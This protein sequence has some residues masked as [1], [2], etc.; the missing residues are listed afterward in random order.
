MTEI[1]TTETKYNA[2]KAERQ[3]YVDAVLNSQSKKNIVV[4]GPGTG[5]THLFKQVLKGKT[6]TLTL[7]FVNPLV[8]DLSLELC[9]ISDVRTLHGFARSALGTATSGTVKVFPKLSDVIKEDAK[10]LL[11]KD[12]NFDHIFHNRDD[13]NEHIEFY[14]KRKNYYDKHYGYSDIIFAIVKHFESKKDKIPSYE[15]VVVDEFQ[16]F[17]KLEVSLIDLLAE[18]SPILLAGDDDQALYDFKSASPEHIRKRHAVENTDYASFTLPY[19]SRCT[20]VIVEATNDII[21]EATKNGNLNGRINKDYKYFDDEIKDK[22]CDKHP[23]IGYGQ[24][25]AKQIPWFIEQRI[26]EIAEHEK[27][28][29]SVLII[30]PTKVQIRSIVTALK[31]KGFANIQFVEKKD[32]K[33][34]NL[35]DGLKV[36]LD[37]SKSNLGW[38][39]VSK[40]LLSEADFKA[41]IT[42]TATD[43]TKNVSDLINKAHKKDV[44]RMLKILRAIKD[45]KKVDEAKLDA[46]LKKVD[47]EPY[48]MA[49]E[50]LKSEISGSQKGGN[51][52][53]R[54][55]PIK[56]TTIQSS[57]GL[58]AEYVFITNFDDQ[59]FIKNKDKKKITDQ[60][61][62]NLLVAL[63]RAKKKVF[64]ISSN[65]KKEPTFLKWINKDRIEKIS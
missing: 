47:I 64:L 54:K 10:I 17:N 5:K 27:G 58:A 39:I 57:K 40:S 21:K 33:E 43:E 29:F 41:L 28:N 8:E 62:C 11:G 61:I 23:K 34:A 46:L 53:V 30:S 12:I 26:G 59:Y 45:D 60:D 37:D 24:L 50:F 65:T 42:T 14:K 7:T 4:A 16:D 25:Y 20:R 3:K 1:I 36:L 52:G 31:N 51:A 56:A 63:T 13:E 19:C 32:G 44:D 9:G 38:R 49:K 6:K 35:M 48:E 15:Q 55:I 22:D 2:S 18:K